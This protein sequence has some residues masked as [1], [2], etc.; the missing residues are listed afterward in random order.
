[1]CGYYGGDVAGYIIRSFLVNV[2]CTARK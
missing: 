2:F 1:V